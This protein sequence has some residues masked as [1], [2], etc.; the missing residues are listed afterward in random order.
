MHEIFKLKDQPQYSLRYNSLFSW[1]LVK[2]VYKGTQ[3][4]SCL[5]PK[6]WDILLDTYNDIADLNSFKVALK[7]RRPVNFPCRIC[8]V[9][10][11]NV[12]FV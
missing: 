2:S 5:G 4:L 3:S 8:K 12:G 9:Y 10:V 1:P 6:M 7:K 11:A